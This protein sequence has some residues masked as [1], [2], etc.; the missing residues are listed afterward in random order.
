MKKHL[1]FIL[2]LLPY[3]AAICQTNN[4]RTPEYDYAMLRIIMMDEDHLYLLD[5]NNPSYIVQY[6]NTGKEIMLKDTLKLDDEKVNFTEA[7]FR[8]FIYMN[9]QG[10]ELATST[11]YA[12]SASVGIKKKYEYVFKRLKQPNSK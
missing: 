8:C 3:M 4:T 2:L 5:R 1:L 10:Y 7:R 6:S 12:Y 11:C 9:R